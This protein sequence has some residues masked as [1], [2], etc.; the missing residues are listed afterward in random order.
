MFRTATGRLPFCSS[1]SFP[2]LTF[3]L[4]PRLRWAGWGRR[5]NPKNGE[6]E[7]ERE[8]KRP[9]VAMQ[10]LFL[11]SISLTDYQR[12]ER[13]NERAGIYINSSLARSLARSLSLSCVC[14]SLSLSLPHSHES[15]AFRTRRIEEKENS[16]TAMRERTRRSQRNLNEFCV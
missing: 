15:A 10:V 5:E 2:S 11:F 12:T 13:E 7:R 8:R 3:L 16:W 6:R 14:V 4:L 1:L 9:V